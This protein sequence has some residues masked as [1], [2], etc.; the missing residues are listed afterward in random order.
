MWNWK[1]R[2]SSR[3]SHDAWGYWASSQVAWSIVLFSFSGLHWYLLGVCAVGRTRFLSNLSRL[4]G[5]ASVLSL[6]VILEAT[7]GTSAQGSLQP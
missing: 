7:L 6:I 2:R 3:P 4:L 1:E 5:A